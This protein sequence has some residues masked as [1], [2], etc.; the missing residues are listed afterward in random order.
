MRLCYFL[1]QQSFSR[2]IYFY[3]NLITSCKALLEICY[4]NNLSLYLNIKVIFVNF[5]LIFFNPKKIIHIQII[6]PA[7]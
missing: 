7:T 5:I 3:K 1:A 6:V 2:K 4:I